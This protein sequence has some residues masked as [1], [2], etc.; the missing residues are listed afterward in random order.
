MG[1]I[2]IGALSLNLFNQVQE[3]LMLAELAKLEQSVNLAQAASS[4]R[5]TSRPFRNIQAAVIYLGYW[6]YKF[7]T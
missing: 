7:F 6:L 2:P 1:K 5:R 3:P 4:L